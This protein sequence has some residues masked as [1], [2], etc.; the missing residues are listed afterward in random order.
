[1]DYHQ[2][3]QA[4]VPPEQATPAAP[5]AGDGA[6]PVPTLP[7]YEI[8]AEL[9]RGG[10]GVVY[11][12][13]QI[14]LN[15]T[16][17]LKMI[18][19]GGHAG[20]TELARFRIEAEAVARLQHVGIVQIHET[21]V[22]NG[23]P[24]FSLEFVPGGSLDRKL[25]GSPLPPLASAR[26]TCL[27][28]QAIHAAHANG[29]LHRD[30]KPANVFLQPTD[31]R[32]GVPIE[33]RAGNSARFLPKIGDF[34]LAKKLDSAP[35]A[36]AAGMTQ[37][38]AIMGTPSYMAPEQAEGKSKELTPAV[39][40]YALG[41]ILYE[42]QTGRPPFR[43]AT[44]LETLLQVVSDEPV[45]PS[46]LNAK[47]PPDLE[48][49]CLKCLQKDPRKRYASAHDLAE[50]LERF[51]KG[52][53]IQARPVGRLERT[54]RWCRRNPAV[55]GLIG[56][57][58]ATLLV[59]IVVSSAL[60][61]FAFAKAELAENQRQAAEAAEKS[62]KDNEE[63]ALE[64]AARNATLAQEKGAL[65]EKESRLAASNA[66]LAQ[67]KGELAL[68]EK[69]Q[70][71]KAEWRLYL[72]LIAHADKDLRDGDVGRAQQWLEDCPAEQRG[73]EHGYLWAICRQQGREVC[74]YR[75]HVNTVTFS[76]GGSRLATSGFGQEVK[77][78]DA[79]TGQEVGA[80]KGKITGAS[81]AY[82]PDGK[83]I[84][85]G[86][87][88][89]GTGQVLGWDAETGMQTL[90]VKGLAGIPY[91]VA[92][93]PDGKRIVGGGSDGVVKV[94][95]AQTGLEVHTLKGHS[96]AVFSVAFGPDGK[97]L[98]SGS[99]DATVKLWDADKGQEIRSLQGTG[100][101]V[102]SVAF[103]PDGKRIVSGGLDRTVKLFDA[104]TGQVIRTLRG[105]TSEVKAVAFTRDGKWVASACFDLTVKVW[106]AH[107]G[108]EFRTFKGHA[109]IV[110][111]VAF[112]PD[113]QQVVS[114]GRDGLIKFWA[115][116]TSPVARALQGHKA[117][118]AC[119]A[120]SPDGTRI[121]SSAFTPTSPCELKVWNAQT[122]QEEFS[123]Q[124]H[125]GSVTSATFSP[126]GKRLA[127]GSWD[128]TAKV[129]DML[130][131]K[132]LL[133]LK[134]HTETVSWV[135]FSPDGKRLVS[136][137]AADCTVRV[138][139]A[140]TGQQIFARKG[141]TGNVNCVAFSAD[142]KQFVSCSNEGPVKVWDAETGAEIRALKGHLG[143]VNRVV[144]SPDGKRIATCGSDYTV[145]IWD[146]QTGAEIR[147]V[148]G[149]TSFVMGLA[150]SPD[151]KRLVSCSWDR[152]VK[153]WET[154]TGQEIL[155]LRGHTHLV[156][157]V[158]FSPDGQRLATGGGAA[159]L[160]GTAELLVWDTP[161]KDNTKPGGP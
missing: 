96:K 71:L 41:A 118:I 80:L 53:P 146:A 14:A 124:G 18:L 112:S 32:D 69:T 65:A 31:A 158:S 147:A 5:E 13:R 109:D 101:P 139:D 34:G 59:G 129:W 161:L 25:Q 84:V 42:L 137:G 62:A 16:V 3:E 44:S 156:E 83:R 6:A 95:D 141:H 152:T 37:T 123:L 67:E 27:L 92:Y 78:W 110:E 26:L 51:L 2:V 121:A 91:S 81:P 8:L 107:T 79:A 159:G 154:E 85:T 113:G 58:A 115:L 76:P 73:W 39:D 74:G 150:F 144:F 114:G 22:I 125:T 50:D 35:G 104:E 28:A 61:V 47:T 1:V 17:A 77:V 132:E 148:R 10:M 97:R 9:G 105:H 106:D 82:S 108:Q 43:S 142:G 135:A 33:D 66:R 133:T 45:P 88:G 90:A 54:W 130:T 151:G 52:E 116:R 122:G 19:A 30:L 145:R 128:R 70:R 40:T 49:I 134:G 94:W 117:R 75:A 7:G 111:C 48:T 55:A 138:W 102:N 60:A 136:S 23:L 20:E 63:L 57:V 149:H 11:M 98:V 100:G 131:G 126:D 153:V 72:E 93:S 99:G 86:S 46:R 12:A 64:L 103:S 127:S 87:G 21:G 29:I 160:P 89:L 155:T 140:Q 4:T 157:A 36:L 56:A 24:Y 68:L 38:G 15:R 120:F 143:Q 119:V